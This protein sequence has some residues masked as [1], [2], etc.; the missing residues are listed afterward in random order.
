[1]ITEAQKISIGQRLSVGFDGPVIPEEYEQLIREYK[2]GT[3]LLFKRNVKSYEQ[4]K[5]AARKRTASR[6]R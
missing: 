2:I 3:V 4:E 1:M 6:K 5:Y